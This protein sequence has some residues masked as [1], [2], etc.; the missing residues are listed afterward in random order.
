MEI[1]FHK[2]YHL[3]IWLDETNQPQE[4][5]GKE[6]VAGVVVNSATNPTG[7]VTGEY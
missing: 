2:T 1:P 3:I 5:Q 6:F 7:Q 4:E